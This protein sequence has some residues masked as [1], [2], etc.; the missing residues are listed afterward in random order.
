MT[1]T[2]PATGYGYIKSEEKLD[3]NKYNVSK[4]NCFIE[5]PDSSTASLL[6]KDK[7][8][9]WNSG[10]FLFKA[11]S[12][13]N[14]I[15]KF[16]PEIIKACEKCL[17]NSTRDLDFLRLDKNSFVKCENISIDIAVFEKTKK[18]FVIP[19]DCGWDDI[20]S[21]KSLWKMSNKDKDGNSKKGKVLIKN[22][23]IP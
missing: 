7:K 22:T 13:L 23:K 9:S 14:E 8:Y 10:I 21:W 18:A 11:S 2:Y 12:I 5:K 16:N 20:G 19:L 1:P 6:I 15:K 17:A 4:V 3:P